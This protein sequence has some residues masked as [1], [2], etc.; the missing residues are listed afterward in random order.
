MVLALRLHSPHPISDAGIDG[1]LSSLGPVASMWSSTKILLGLLADGGFFYGEG[2]HP[3]AL[4]S[5]FAMPTIFN[6]EHVIAARLKERE[7][8]R[9]ID[10]QI[11]EIWVA[12][13]LAKILDC[14]VDVG[15]LV[16]GCPDFIGCY[17]ASMSVINCLYLTKTTVGIADGAAAS[18]NG[19]MTLLIDSEQS[20]PWSTVAMHEKGLQTGRRKEARFGDFKSIAVDFGV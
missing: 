1:C 6:G 10:D 19:S 4:L 12:H 17:S 16:M 20:L 2:E 9:V 5:A 15:S 8:Q 3:E 7:G 18:G 13:L 11:A 14:I